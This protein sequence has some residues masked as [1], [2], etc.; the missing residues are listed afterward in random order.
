[1]NAKWQRAYKKRLAEQPP[2]VNLP[3][4]SNQAPSP[5][6]SPLQEPERPS[7]ENLPGLQPVA[8]EKMLILHQFGEYVPSNVRPE[9]LPK[10]PATAWYYVRY[11]NAAPS[12]AGNR[13]RVTNVQV[14]ITEY[15]NAAWA[16]YKISQHGSGAELTHP[17]KVVKFGNTIYGQVEE[18]AGWHVASYSWRSGNRIIALW[19]YS[20]DSEDILKAYLQKFPASEMPA[21][22]NTAT[23]FSESP[24]LE[25][26]PEVQLVAPKQR[27]IV[28][29]FGE[30]S[31]SDVRSGKTVARSNPWV[32]NQITSPNSQVPAA[33]HYSVHYTVPDA[34]PIGGN[35]R[36]KVEVYVEEYPNAAWAHYEV[37]QRQARGGSASAPRPVKFGSFLYGHEEDGAKG[38]NGSYMW[39]SGNRLISMSFDLAAPDEILKA[40]LEK[41]PTSEKASPE[42]IARAQA[43]DPREILKQVLLLQQFGAYLPQRP[44]MAMTM[45]PPTARY[46]TVRYALPNAPTQGDTGPTVD[47]H[48]Y[49]YAN[50]ALAK[51]EIFGQGGRTDLANP[52]RPVKFGSRIYGQAQPAAARQ[53]G[54]YTNGQN[55]EYVWASGNRLIVVQAYSAEPDEIVKA[56]LAKFLPPASD[57]L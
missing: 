35:L 52:A 53:N 31:P 40:Y 11:A 16:R 7:L 10:A 23:Q 15:P 19:S 36:P 4:P 44:S 21:L 54:A 30:Y 56:Y 26:L 38:R 51:Y 47:V 9:P 17:A 12:S 22:D 48:I 41:F 3:N 42:D 14:Q 5:K 6:A 37:L 39:A 27:L 25:D 33:L 57:R 55:G 49:E 18:S 8:P 46:Y 24:S 2:L 32:N 13:G 29:T 1:Q 50:A 43:A 45:R 28:Q 34:A 20:V